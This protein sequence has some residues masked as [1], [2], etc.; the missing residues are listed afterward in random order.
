MDIIRIDMDKTKTI[1]HRTAG[2]TDDQ[3]RN[4]TVEALDAQVNTAELTL[5]RLKETVEEQ[6]VRLNNLKLIRSRKSE[7]EG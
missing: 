7:L 3:I 2:W 6:Q 5:A 4:Q 1:E